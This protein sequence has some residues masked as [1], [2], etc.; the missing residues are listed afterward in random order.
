MKYVISMIALLFVVTACTK[1]YDEKNVNYYITGLANQYKV[2]YIDEN[3]KTITEVVNPVND[4][5][6][7]QYSF[8]GIQGDIVYLY[9]EFTDPD[10]VPSKFK[11]R[12]YVDNKVFKESFGYDMSIGDTLFKVRR[13]GV[14]P[15]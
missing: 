9:A 13:S 10:L 14:I 15:F 6:I 1:E 7:W 2:S 12:I 3:G 5:E 4:N 8:T 11:F